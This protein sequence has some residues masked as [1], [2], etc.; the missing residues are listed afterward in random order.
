MGAAHARPSELAVGDAELARRLASELVGA[1]T[2]GQ[3]FPATH[4]KGSCRAVRNLGH[5]LKW[6]A[7]LFNAVRMQEP[8]RT[9]DGLWPLEQLA[10]LEIASDDLGVATTDVV[11][12]ATVRIL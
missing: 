1:T 4:I 11:A 10:H 9:V 5:N 12:A 6:H 8:C 7:V 3:Y 2:G